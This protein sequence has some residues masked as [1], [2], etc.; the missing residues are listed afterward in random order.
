MPLRPVLFVTLM[1]SMPI[2]GMG[3]YV[4]RGTVMYLF[5]DVKVELVILYKSIENIT[6]LDTPE[7]I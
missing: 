6:L 1:P 4:L 2:W 3:Q 5:V 7:L